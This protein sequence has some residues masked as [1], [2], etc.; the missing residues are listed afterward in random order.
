MKSYSN[1][2]WELLKVYYPHPG[3]KYTVPK[4]LR[5]RNYTNTIFF[6]LLLF[7]MIFSAF[8]LTKEMYRPYT[9]GAAVLA[10][11]TYVFIAAKSF[12]KKPELQ[13]EYEVAGLLKGNFHCPISQNTFFELIWPVSMLPVLF[14]FPI[15]QSIFLI[16]PDIAI[17]GFIVHRRFFYPP[18]SFSIDDHGAVTARYF[19]REVRFTMRDVV[20]IR[21]YNTIRY[22]GM[23]SG[24]LGI[25][26]SLNNGR[27]VY[28]PITASV[29]E[30]YGIQV[31]SMLFEKFFRDLAHK[32][33]FKFRS[34]HKNF[35]RR[36]GW[37]T[38]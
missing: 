26:F 11:L 27:K 18:K 30:Q 1:D 20:F 15:H 9:T 16:V 37:Y 12:R 32:A 10:F 36:D 13:D 22:R 35:F 28:L 34:T 19:N 7:F 25:I 23:R 17:I 8:T 33:G 24:P 21:L 29:S 3:N 5:S 38:F 2:D 31:P 6:G 4:Y 14:T